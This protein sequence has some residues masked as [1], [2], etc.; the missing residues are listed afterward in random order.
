VIS[1]SLERES[2]APSAMR[3]SR[4]SS[5]ITAAS[6]FE[7]REIAEELY[8]EVG[9]IAMTVVAAKIRRVREKL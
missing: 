2:K 9:S 6:S 5:S 8:E 3:A 1:S 4:Q 7:L